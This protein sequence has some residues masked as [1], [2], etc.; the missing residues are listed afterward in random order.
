MGS[1]QELDVDRL[2]LSDNNTERSHQSLPGPSNTAWGSHCGRNTPPTP[3]LHGD[4]DHYV[5]AIWSEAQTAEN[6]RKDH[7]AEKSLSIALIDL[8]RMRR[9]E[10]DCSG[11]IQVMQKTSAPAEMM[12]CFRAHRALTDAYIAV[13]STLQAFET[14]LNLTESSQRNHKRP[15]SATKRE[16]AQNALLG[17]VTTLHLPNRM[18]RRSIKRPLQL[19]R[20]PAWREESERHVAN[21]YLSMTQHPVFRAEWCYYL[22]RLAT[23]QCSFEEYSADYW[24]RAMRWDGIDHWK[25]VARLVGGI[26][27]GLC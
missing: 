23:M 22:E 5:L 17:Y 19:M 4:D 2:R 24:R 8:S 20:G 14:P 25:L 7:R 13:L 3:H 15:R 16:E 6:A 9:L 12:E 1:E 21:S 18:W 26:L 10:E 11:R 27:K